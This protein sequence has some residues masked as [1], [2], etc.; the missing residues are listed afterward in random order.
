MKST[1]SSKVLAILAHCVPFIVSCIAIMLIVY[2]KLP[3]KPHEFSKIMIVGYYIVAYFNV[4][5]ERIL[6][7]FY[8]MLTFGSFLCEE[9]RVNLA[10]EIVDSRFASCWSSGHIIYVVLS[11]LS[12]T[13]LYL[14]IFI[15]IVFFSLEY[16]KSPLPFADDK[17]IPRC[18]VFVQK[19]ILSILLIYDRQVIFI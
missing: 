2:N 8:S 7:L 16:F 12:M 15:S 3:H 4:I 14:M 19:M 18:I 5:A 6:M 13:L 10:E 1:T 9:E 11:I 17:I